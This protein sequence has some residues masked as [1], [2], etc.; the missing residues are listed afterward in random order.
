MSSTISEYSLGSYA[1]EDERVAALTS[2]YWLNF[3]RT[4]DPN[5]A[6]L[7]A[8]PSYRTPGAPLL[9]IDAEPKAAPDP[10]RARQEF[11]ASV[12]AQGSKR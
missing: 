12:V 3:I 11:L 9:G 8:W 10:F 4:G 6:G 5:G 2:S 1:P 7:P